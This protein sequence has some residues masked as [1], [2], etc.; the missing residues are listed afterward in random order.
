MIGASETLIYRMENIS[1]A[2][3]EVVLDS[4]HANG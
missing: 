2:L 4:V 1:V 3:N